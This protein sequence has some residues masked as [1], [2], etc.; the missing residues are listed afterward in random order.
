MEWDVIV[1]Q[2][3]HQ[4]VADEIFVR[5]YTG[6]YAKGNMLPSIITLSKETKTSPETIRKAIKTLMKNNI[7]TKSKN[8]FWVTKDDKVINEYKDIYIGKYKD[9]YLNAIKKLSIAE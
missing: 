7:V 5:I 3:V 9:I 6:A 8:S 1:E 4:N 2:R